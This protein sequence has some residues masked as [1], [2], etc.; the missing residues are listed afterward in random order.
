MSNYVIFTDSACDIKQETLNE[1]G[2]KY[3][4]LSFTFSGEERQ[5]SNYDLTAKEFYQRMR[6]GA[7]AKT[8][9]ANTEGFIDLFEPELKNGNDVLYLGF[10]SGLSGTY[11]CAR[12]AGEELSEKYPERKIITIDTLSAS[13]GFGL[14]LYLTVRKKE[15][16]ATLEEAA[17]YAES[18]K[19]HL[20]HW[21]T[22]DDLV[23]LKRGGRISPTV[24]LVGSVLGIKPVLHMDDEGH[25]ISRFKVRGRK[26]AIKALADK[27][28]ELA[29]E[30]GRD[31]I[32]ISHGDCMEDA[33]TLK[34]ILGETYAVDVEIITDVGPVIGAHSGPGTLALFFIGKTR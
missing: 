27:F 6:D 8:S 31:H 7:S 21:F 33:L 16:G 24:A 20:C 1:W 32:F 11:N 10:S 18:L 25:L 34:K 26:A 4:A 2:V 22:V 23:Y 15:E 9:A 5:Y 14:M 19:A 28:G 29:Q 13:A 3:C 12:M 17:A 30:N